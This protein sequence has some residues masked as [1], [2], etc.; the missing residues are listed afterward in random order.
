MHAHL[1]GPR[2]R[3]SGKERDRMCI[4]WFKESDQVPLCDTYTLFALTCTQTTPSY[5]FLPFYSVFQDRC[6]AS[7]T[8]GHEADCRS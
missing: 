5:V 8:T 6:Y 3:V 2:Q 1:Q 4:A 7:S